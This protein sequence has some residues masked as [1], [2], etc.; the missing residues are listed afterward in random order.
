[1]NE[2]EKEIFCETLQLY[3]LVPATHF[4]LSK[5]TETQ[6]DE[7]QRLLEE[8]LAQQRTEHRK[9][10]EALL[11]DPVRFKKIGKKFRLRLK[12]TELDWL[13]QVFNDI[14]VG[15][16]L[17]LGEPDDDKPPTV[18]PENFRY[19]LAM[20]VSGMF[21]SALLAALGENESPDWQAET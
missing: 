8:S 13:L 6:S 21:Q 11:N 19:G 12:I 15:C 1:M 17:M 2:P 10:L 9:E 18:T 3:P 14:R 16:W 5:A 4:R 7:N 20:D